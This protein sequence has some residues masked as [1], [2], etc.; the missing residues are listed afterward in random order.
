LPSSISSNGNSSSRNSSTGDS[1]S[2]RNASTDSS[3]KNKSSS[4][5]D[6]E[7][8]DSKVRSIRDGAGFIV[9]VP[10]SLKR[11]VV[12]DGNLAE[13]LCYMGL[14]SSIVGRTDAQCPPQLL[15]VRSVG[16]A[17]YA[18]N[19]EAV[20]ELNPDII[21]ADQLLPYDYYETGAYTKLKNAGIPI[22]I[23]EPPTSA[24]NPLQMTPE[25]LYNAPTG[26]DIVCSVM[27]G[28]STVVGN[29]D[30]VDAYVTW[31]QSYN[32]L[33]KDRIAELPRE[34]Q[35]IAFFEW[36]SFPYYT[37]ID[38]HLYQA[39]GLNI[40]E[41]MT[42]AGAQYS[43]EQVVEQNPSVIITLVS[44]VTHDVNDFINA[45]TEVIN[46]PALK[47]VDAVK[48]G[49]VYVCDF[50]AL[51]GLRSIIGYLYWAK[52]IQPDLFS[53]IDPAKVTEQLNQQYLGTPVTEVYCY[54]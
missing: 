42:T 32:K 20:L 39:G 43:P 12:L 40:A 10:E 6:A 24:Q 38:L 28:L 17:G 25:E 46:R 21:I 37:T 34:Q 1:S 29:K 36:N 13:M 16:E 15:N 2:P 19:V 8:S 5:S 26:I 18:V 14:Q 52:W 50:N 31:A 4:S 30:K 3:N 11:I 54:P 33:V 41:N 27:Q 48:N 47:D 23:S 45:R 35:T 53:D 44:S 7:S 22:Y 9:N 51:N 49:R